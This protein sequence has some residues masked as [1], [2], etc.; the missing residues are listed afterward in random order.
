MSEDGGMMVCVF[1]RVASFV[2]DVDVVAVAAVDG[3]VI[4][5]VSVAYAS[6]E[7]DAGEE[8][9]GIIVSPVASVDGLSDMS[10][11]VQMRL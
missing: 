8:M 5:D 2:S 1:R 9:E 4:V 7:M 3:G 10:L 11:G 6:V